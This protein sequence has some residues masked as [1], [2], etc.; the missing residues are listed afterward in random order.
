VIDDPNAGAP[1]PN[2]IIP[3]SRLS[4]NGIGIL[5]LYPLPT[6]GYISGNQN[7]I[8]QASQP[9]NQRKETINS[10]ILPSTKDRPI[11]AD[12]F[13]VL[14][15]GSVRSGHERNAQGVPPAESGEFA[16]LDAHVQPDAAE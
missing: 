7:W 13:R 2:N 16:G 12:E 15:A 11:P 8:A 4:P 9:E 10:D 1:F 3:T 6:T 5:S 14:R